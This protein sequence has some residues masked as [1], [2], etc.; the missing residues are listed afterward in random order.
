MVEYEKFDI[1]EVAAA[2]G[3]ELNPRTLGRAEVEAWCPFCPTVSSGCH[4][5]L[6]PGKERF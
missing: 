2:C 4:L 5:Y 3:I 6:N 1:V